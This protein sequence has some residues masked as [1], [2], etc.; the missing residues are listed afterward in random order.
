[1]RLI[2]VNFAEMETELDSKLDGMIDK[3]LRE[4]PDYIIPDSFT[5]ELVRKLEKQLAWKELLSE[6]GLKSGLVLASLGI[7]TICLI[8]PSMGSQ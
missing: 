1:M 2:N 3:A 8:Y 7:M 6:F 4:P 5:E